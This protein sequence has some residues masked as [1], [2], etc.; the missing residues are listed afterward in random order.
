MGWVRRS[1]PAYLSKMSQKKEILQ[2]K[3]CAWCLV[4]DV[5]KLSACAGCKITYYCSVHCQ[6]KH[7]K[8]GGHKQSCSRIEKKYLSETGAQTATEPLKFLDRKDSGLW[9]LDTAAPGC[10]CWH[11]HEPAAPWMLGAS[12]PFDPTDF[13]SFFSNLVDEWTISIMVA[14][15]RITHRG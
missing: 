14:I 7:W 15:M 4:D 9:F 1:D 2:G 5:T 3:H 13:V 10:Y 6:K 11:G 8:L 12:A